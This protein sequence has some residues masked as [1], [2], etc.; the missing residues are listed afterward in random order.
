MCRLLG[1]SRSGVYAARRRPARTS[2]VLAEQVQ[3]AFKASG[4][5]YGSRRLCAALQAE[6]V[7]AGRCRVRR[8]M[9]EFGLKPAWRRKFVHTTDSRHELPVAENG[10]R[11][12]T[13][14]RQPRGSP[15]RHR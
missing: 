10:T 9:R 2:G 8:L 12:A 15:S 3:A 7:T 5:C 6:G 1:V 14:L 11:L 13:R 4:A